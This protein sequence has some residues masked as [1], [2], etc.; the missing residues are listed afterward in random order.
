MDTDSVQT[1][2]Q[3]IS[4]SFPQDASIAIADQSRFIFYKPGRSIDLKIKPGDEI[5]EG[6]LTGLALKKRTRLSR[7]LQKSPF[8]VPYYAISTPIIN[9]GIT[10]GCFTVVYPSLFETPLPRR[11][12][13]VGKT[14]G[15]WIPVPFADIHL[16]ESE[17]GKTFFH[18]DNG[19][20]VTKHSLVELEQILPPDQFIRCHR[21]YLV[22]VNKIAEIHPDFHSTFV[23]VMKHDKLLRVPVSQSYASYF[24]QFLGF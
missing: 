9:D 15:R 13:L 24:R 5:L 22:N 4:D 19:K 3:A 14:E 23:L 11:Q 21:A 7:F 10:T 16:L 2:I 8:G 1:I 12:F 17:T 18:T 20:Y 6:T